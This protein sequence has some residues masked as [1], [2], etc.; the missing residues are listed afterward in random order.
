M[1]KYN[2]K[3]SI[4]S[5]F[6]RIKIIGT[7]R[8]AYY[9][10]HANSTKATLE[11]AAAR[12]KNREMLI[13]QK[14]SQHYSIKN[15]LKFNKVI[16]LTPSHV[17]RSG[18]T[19]EADLHFAYSESLHE[20]GIP[21]QTIES[22]TNLN[23]DKFNEGTLIIFDGNFSLKFSSEMLNQIDLA[24]NKGCYIAFDHTDLLA[25]K[26]ANKI[27][28]EL[29]KIADVGIIHNPLIDLSEN[30]KKRT[31]LWP[32]YPFSKIFESEK[33]IKKDDSVLFSGTSFRGLNG[34][35]F[36]LNYLSKH[37]VSVNNQMLLSKSTGQIHTSYLDY[38]RSLESCTMS[39]TTGYRSNE[40]SLLVFRVVELMLRETVVFYEEGSFIN[41]F[42]RPYEH[43]IPV[44]NAPDLLYKV[45]YLQNNQ[46]LFN[47]IV[48]QAK[49][50]TQRKYS[51]YLF[52]KKL[53][54]KL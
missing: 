1:K 18:I 23:I 17:Q 14:L 53:N 2:F 39:F 40:E 44:F 33:L 27:L 5:I 32:T 38:L 52:W 16:L 47:K 4:L 20:I 29:Y 49:E 8:L 13:K 41:H 42:F 6:R 19:L 50:F 3:A 12:I 9:L 35:K 46:E 36:Y 51:H 21:V 31:I 43:Y 34:R 10:L 28:S 54:E 25:S 24:R 48:S 15:E 22:S 30:F 26:D 45:N 11:T 37:K 7:G